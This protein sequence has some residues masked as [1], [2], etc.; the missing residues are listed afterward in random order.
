MESTKTVYV[1][2]ALQV[3]KDADIQ[4]INVACTEG[5]G[6]Y[7]KTFDEWLNSQ[8]LQLTTL[9]RLIAGLAVEIPLEIKV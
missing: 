3:L 8:P 5:T 1:K 6:E 7:V 9:T 2:V 4:D